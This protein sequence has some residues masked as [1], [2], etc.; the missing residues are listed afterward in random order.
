MYITMC[1]IDVQC[2]FYGL[3]RATKEVFW[4]N[5]EGRVEREVRGGFQGMGIHVSLWLIHVDM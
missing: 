5:L 1:E 2:K 4:G 3:S